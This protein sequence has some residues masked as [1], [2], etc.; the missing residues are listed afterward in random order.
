[1]EGG[2]A[3]SMPSRGA[4]PSTLPVCRRAVAGI[5]TSRQTE[6]E[7][8]CLPLTWLPPPTSV[9]YHCNTT[10]LWWAVCHDAVRNKALIWTDSGS[11][12]PLS[13]PGMRRWQLQLIML[14]QLSA[15]KREHF[16][17]IDALSHAWCFDSSEHAIISK[18]AY[19][20]VAGSWIGMVDPQR[21]W[22]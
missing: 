5:W 18:I 7:S 6:T 22:I 1:M 8:S 2:I 21:I 19:W 15:P 12:Q 9:T 4:R 13:G 3:P 20:I 11:G 16:L 10:I 14:L 17:L